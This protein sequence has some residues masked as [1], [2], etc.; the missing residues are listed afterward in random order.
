MEGI[1]EKIDYYIRKNPEKDLSLGRLAELFCFNSSYLS[2]AFHQYKGEALSSYIIR[3]RIERAKKLL[4]DTDE[5]IYEIAARC[6]F[7]TPAYFSRMFVPQGIPDEKERGNDAMNF[8]CG[9]QISR[10]GGPTEHR[11]KK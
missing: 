4:L 11:L 1:M 9:R 7:E 3:I 10:G 2:R 8:G 6:G 5:K